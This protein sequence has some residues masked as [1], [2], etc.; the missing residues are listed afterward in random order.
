M[1]YRNS[2][3]YGSLRFKVGFR[4]EVDK[5]IKAAKKHATTLKE[6]KNTIICPCKDCKNRMAW[7]DMTIIRSHLIMRGFVDDTQC[8]FIMVKRLLLT[9]R[10][11]RNT[12][13][14]P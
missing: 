8:G 4:E 12:T 14:K 10:M 5:F 9:T 1:E 6:N 2:W 11:R 13:T 7:T 3:M